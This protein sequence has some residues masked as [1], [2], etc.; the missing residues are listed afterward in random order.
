VA[1]LRIP[2]RRMP[3]S[4]RRPDCLCC[5][6]VT[7]VSAGL[8]PPRWPHFKWGMSAMPWLQHTPLSDSS[9]CPDSLTC[10][11]GSHFYRTASEYT[12]FGGDRRK[13]LATLGRIHSFG[14]LIGHQLTSIFT[15]I[16][17]QLHIYEGGRELWEAK[18][19]P[20]VMRPW[21][22]YKS[23]PYKEKTLCWT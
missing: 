23:P 9:S 3:I 22:G 13:G 21:R 12:A 20:R 1:R 18:G 14:G 8:F 5:S 7:G 16:G 10:L 15:L 4:K 2:R 11:S 6:K 19:D 17:H